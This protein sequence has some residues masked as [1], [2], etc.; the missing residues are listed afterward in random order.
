MGG[1]GSAS[2]RLEGEARGQLAILKLL[3][4]FLRKLRDRGQIIRNS[5]PEGT[6]DSQSTSSMF[7]GPNQ[8]KVGMR[9]IHVLFTYHLLP[10]HPAVLVPCLHL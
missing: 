7:L 5:K 10:L 1:K 9:E 6:S 8:L 3:N 2:G 4:L